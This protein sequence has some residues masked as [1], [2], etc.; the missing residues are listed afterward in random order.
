[1]Y[2]KINLVIRVDIPDNPL[3]E[4]LVFIEGDEGAEG[5]GFPSRSGLHDEAGR[6]IQGGRQGEVSDQGQQDDDDQAALASPDPGVLGAFPGSDVGSV[7]GEGFDA[8]GH[9][10]MVLYTQRNAGGNRI[11]TVI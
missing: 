1:M 11:L 7:C 2:I 10:L 4:N 8:A 5:P 9:E 6:E 3:D